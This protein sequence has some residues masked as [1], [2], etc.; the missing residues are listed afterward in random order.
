MTFAKTWKDNWNLKSMQ[1]DDLT[2]VIVEV[3]TKQLDEIEKDEVTLSANLVIDYEA[4][5][6]D[7]VAMLLYLKIC[8]KMLQK[9]LVQLFLQI[10]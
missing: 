6:V 5:S 1:F 10:N 3:V 7:I 9:L 4:D 2:N 8:L